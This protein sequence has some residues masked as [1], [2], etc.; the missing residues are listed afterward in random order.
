MPSRVSA[1]RPSPALPVGRGRGPGG[2][3]GPSA[4]QGGRCAVPGCGQE[5]HISR[6]MC[7]DDWY[8]VPKPLRDRV[9]AAWRSGRAATATERQEPVRM[10]VH[11]S[12]ARRGYPSG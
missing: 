8:A 5:I 7:R 2:Q 3:S 4:A 1:R 12:Q 6:L 10:A 9:R 11:A